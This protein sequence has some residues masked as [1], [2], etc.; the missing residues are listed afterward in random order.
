M[1]RRLLTTTVLVGVASV[2]LVVPARS[3]AVAPSID[4][5]WVTDV[6]PSDATLNAEINPNGLLTYYELQID[7]TGNFKFFQ[8]TS[9]PLKHAPMIC[10]QVIVPGDPLPPGLVQPPES[11]LAAGFGAQHV[12][13]NMAS[14][15]ATL[16][17]ETTYYYRAIAANGFE[18]VEGPTQTFATP[19]GED[20]PKEGESGAPETPVIDEGPGPVGDP[21]HDNEMAEPNGASPA[22]SAPSALQGGASPSPLR[23]AKRCQRRKARQRGGA[24]SP[25]GPKRQLPRPKRCSRPARASVASSTASR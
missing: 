22:N 17:P 4:A 13:V 12:S 23:K 18:L 14:I 16:Q 1:R 8:N 3:V 10:L 11:T 19:S 2:L 25:I 9:C 7:T 15:S 21:S 20:L 5:Q 24:S 6:M